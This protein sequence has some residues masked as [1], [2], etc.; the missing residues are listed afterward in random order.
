MR[1]S[2]NNKRSMATF[3]VRKFRSQLLAAAKPTPP[4]GT[5][6]IIV[7]VEQFQSSIPAF[8]TQL[9]TIQSSINLL[10]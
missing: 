8:T 1:L 2:Q 3:S 10:T 4:P 9:S 7:G 5:S 6:A